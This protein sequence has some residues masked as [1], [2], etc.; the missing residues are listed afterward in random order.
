MAIFNIKRNDTKPPLDV[1]L[2][3]GGVVVDL[4]DCSVTFHMSTIIDSPAII[5]DATAGAVTYNWIAADTVTGGQFPAE[6]EV[7]FSDGAIETFPNNGY[8]TIFVYDDLA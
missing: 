2:S 6:F 3:Q 8:L 5:T 1:I 7:V 4:S